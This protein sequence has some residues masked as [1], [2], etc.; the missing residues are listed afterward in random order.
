MSSTESDIVTLVLDARFSDWRRSEL[1]VPVTPLEYQSDQHPKY[2]RGVPSEISLVT[3]SISL[4]SH[5]AYSTSDKTPR[6]HPPSR[7]L[8]VLWMTASPPGRPTASPGVALQPPRNP[9]LLSPHPDPDPDLGDSQRQQTQPRVA[10]TSRT[11]S[12]TTV[13]RHRPRPPHYGYGHAAEHTDADA[14]ECPHSFL[15]LVSG[16]ARGRG[17]GTGEGSSE[18][19]P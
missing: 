9:S 5:I 13:D 14:G 12:A 6:T 16:G 3:S 1:S 17:N 2:L 10:S 18:D 8:R 4:T 19:D 11:G 15:P 7:R